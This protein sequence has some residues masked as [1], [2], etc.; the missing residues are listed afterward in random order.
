MLSCQSFSEI[1]RILEKVWPEYIPST[2]HVVNHPEGKFP[3]D[4]INLPSALLAVCLVFGTVNE[5]S[6]VSVKISAE[7]RRH[8]RIPDGTDGLARVIRTL[9]G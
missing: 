1:L 4:V 6:F 9:W 3:S 7:G 8:P 2:Q 5:N